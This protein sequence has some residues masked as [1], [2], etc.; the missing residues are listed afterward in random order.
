MDLN[1]YTMRFGKY[2]GTLLKD[3]P[4]DYMAWLLR[5]NIIKGPAKDALEE[6]IWQRIKEGKREQLIQ[7]WVNNNYSAKPTHSSRYEGIDPQDMGYDCP[8]DEWD[9]FG[10]LT[11]DFGF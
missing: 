1:E 6:I 2:K 8:Y 10:N 9:A 5:D 4:K 11:V 7:E 3:L